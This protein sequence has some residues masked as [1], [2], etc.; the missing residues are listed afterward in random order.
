MSTVRW[1]VP[2]QIR[3]E[4]TGDAV[5]ALDAARGGVHRLTGP[6]AEVL[7]TVAAADAPLALPA[8]QAAVAEVL[9]AEGLLVAARPAGREISRRSALTA[10][11][12]AAIGLTTLMLPAAA[13]AASV[14]PADADF[15]EGAFSFWVFSEPRTFQFA[16]AGATQG[17]VLIVG[18]GGGGS[19][20]SA[21]R[22][23][24]YSGDYGGA[25]GGG[26]ATLIRAA[27][28]LSGA[29]TVVVGEGGAGGAGAA[30]PEL[31]LNQAFGSDGLDGG[32]SSFGGSSAAGG[33][34][35]VAY[36][37]DA[38]QDNGDQSVGNPGNPDKGEGGDG[39][40]ANDGFAGGKGGEGRDVAGLERPGGA[41][42]SGTD[43]EGPW[44]VPDD[45][46]P[47][48]VVEILGVGGGGG[49]G[50]NYQGG[51]GTAP[52]GGG[53]G[54]D[55]GGDGEAG[56]YGGGG[57]GGGPSEADDPAGSGAGGRGGHGLVIVRAPSAL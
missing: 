55:K 50:E 8:E 24:E 7:R 21:A 25:G 40:A 17:D 54:G 31:P 10:G 28:A 20:G 32:P 3:L 33:E 48:D 39:G 51:P 23:V 12:A 53:E 34:G 36:E 27:V 38:T 46:T 14:E 49:G 16:A 6:S 45:Q 42:T 13:V 18:A 15:D 11:A 26:G 22:R 56:E 9:E 30:R 19:G 41:G 29:T 35:G 37:F 5:L 52:D 4:S 44:F 2:S 47:G 1:S 43:L 57:G